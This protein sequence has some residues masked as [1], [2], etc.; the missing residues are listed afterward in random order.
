MGR[1]KIDDLP[2]DRTLSRRELSQ[3]SGGFYRDFA[4]FAD[5]MKKYYVPTF[6]KFV[7]KKPGLEHLAGVPK[8]GTFVLVG[9]GKG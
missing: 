1:I 3:V 9:K 6:P 2:Q 4:Y 7:K 5:A 8:G